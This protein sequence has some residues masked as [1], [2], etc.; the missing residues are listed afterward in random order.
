M[1]IGIG[2]GLSVAEV[3]SI[4]DRHG[5]SFNHLFE[6]W[7]SSGPTVNWDYLVTVLESPGVGRSDLVQIIHEELAMLMSASSSS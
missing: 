4:R 3:E 2:L 5:C 7:L 1:E 6:L